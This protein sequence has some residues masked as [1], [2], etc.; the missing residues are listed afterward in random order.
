MSKFLNFDQISRKICY[1]L[2]YQIS[3]IRF[4]IKYIFIRCAFYII[5]VITFS[6]KLVKLKKV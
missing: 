6:I 1:D 4:I 3:I 2:W 5:D